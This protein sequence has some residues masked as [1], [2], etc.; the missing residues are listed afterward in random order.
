MLKAETL[1]PEIILRCK[2]YT[3]SR[4]RVWLTSPS[5]A[6]WKPASVEKTTS[7]RERDRQ[8][9]SCTH[10]HSRNEWHIN[11]TSWLHPWRQPDTCTCTLHELMELKNGVHSAIIGIQLHLKVCT[12]QIH[13]HVHFYGHIIICYCAYNGHGQAPRIIYIRIPVI[14]K[15]TKSCKNHN[16]HTSIIIPVSI[17]E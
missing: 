3:R 1:P 8:P 13:V 14:P 10:A 16:T 2:L 17:F 15:C 11:I 9:M 4:T 5:P 7:F 6:R 12:K